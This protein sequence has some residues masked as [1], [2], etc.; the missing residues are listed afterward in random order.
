MSAVSVL[1]GVRSVCGGGGAMGI[2]GAVGGSK[3]ALAVEGAVRRPA[4]GA[5]H[6]ELELIGAVHHNPIDHLA[7]YRRV[8]S[9]RCGSGRYARAT[10]GQKEYAE[11]TPQT[12]LPAPPAPPDPPA[13]LACQQRK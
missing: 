1:D 8:P 7:L 13:P 4:G 6:V 12:A 2:R 11:L 10:G 9:R 3:T 5:V